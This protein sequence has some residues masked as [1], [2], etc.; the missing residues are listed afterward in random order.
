MDMSTL[1]KRAERALADAESRAKAARDELSALT[2]GKSDLTDDEAKR[3]T[4]LVGELRSARNAV[5]DAESE[6][7][8]V[9]AAAAEEAE[10]DKRSAESRPTP[11]AA[12][13]AEKRTAE[14]SVTREP[15][16][17]AHETD[18]KGKM[19][20]RDVAKNFLYRDPASAQRLER[21]MVEERVE[22]GREL[23]G[24]QERAAGDAASDAFGALVVPQYLLDM[25]APAVAA[26]RPFA[27]ICNRH[28]LPPDGLTLTIPKIT[29]AT[30]V[31]NQSAELAASTPVSLDETDLTVSV[32]TALGEQTL[33]RQAIDRG[34]G[35][36][37]ITMQDLVKRYVT[38]LDSNLLNM[39]T[40]GLEAVATATSTNTTADASLTLDMLYSYI[41]G[42]A[43]GI[44]AA[45]LG[46][47]TPSHVIMHSRRW[48]MLSSKLTSTWPF[49]QNGQLG[50]S[51]NPAVKGNGAGYGGVR[52]V[53]PSGL[54]V[55]VDNN[56]KTN[57]TDGSITNADH[58]YVVPADE[59]HL[60]EDPS[61]PAF[62]RAEQPKASN[63]GVLL[64]L[65]GYY[66][67]TFS[68]MPA[69]A[70]SSVK[71]LPTHTF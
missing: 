5:K 21:H 20:L 15:R 18:P 71:G 39:T 61:A 48:H 19:F 57:I 1:V 16:T 28:D 31:E 10:F 55:V 32:H 30:S 36:E 3:S 59:C 12:P 50:T 64:V 14:F 66:A 62:I 13:A 68:R 45:V 8:E 4:V 22:R 17:Y 23:T 52:G 60:W 49:V 33:S 51:G 65:Y 54:T 41:E 7:A 27:D 42:A 9:R 34:R 53:L 70:M 2:D 25:T 6:L 69:G 35:T 46:L 43:A 29:T 11:A 47:A 56:I 40:Y 44:E 58:L 24:Y 67:F 38:N 37:E 26:M 63:L